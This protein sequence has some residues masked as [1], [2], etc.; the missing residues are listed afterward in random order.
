MAALRRF[1]S[2]RLVGDVLLTTAFLSYSGPFNQE[3]RTK[4]MAAWR[5]MLQGRHIPFTDTLDV[6]SWL[7]DN[8]TVRLRCGY[9]N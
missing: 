8:A 3:Y 5:A 2:H 7:V 1:P 4:M 9:V 6:T